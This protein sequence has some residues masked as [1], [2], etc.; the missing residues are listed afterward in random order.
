M[1]IHL[2]A[3]ARPPSFLAS[4]R[5]M[6]QI[7][8]PIEHPNWDNLLLTN[9]NYSF[10]HTSGWAKVISETYNYQP[11]YF[12]EI[13]NG[14]LNSLIPIMAINSPL[15]GQRGVALPFTD[16]CPVRASDKNHFQE[17]FVKIIEYGKK[18]KWN[19]IEIR[20]GKEFLRDKIPSETYLTH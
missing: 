15:T 10:F 9:D 8:N 20:G 7:I 4:K 17:L 1:L 14:K 12:T 2:I 16:Y 18:A 19:T 11:L 13:D 6:L 5:T 3:A